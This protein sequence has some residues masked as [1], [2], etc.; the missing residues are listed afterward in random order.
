MNWIDITTIVI[1]CFFALKGYQDGLIKQV[2]S[3]VGVVIGAIFAGKVATAIEPGL[4]ELFAMPRRTVGAVSYAT[5]FLLIIFAFMAMGRM[6]RRF[7]NAIRIGFLNNWGGAFF[8]ATKW[9][10]LFSIVLNLVESVDSQ[11]WIIKK[12]VR[13]QSL[14]HDFVKG[15]MPTIVPFLSNHVQT[16]KQLLDPEK[17]QE[18]E[19]EL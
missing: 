9:L 18:K 13:Q 16:A 5:A 19:T 14:T 17:T 15:L 4:A 1:A 6:L 3:I 8:A 11:G 12:E 2:A 7:V 10:L